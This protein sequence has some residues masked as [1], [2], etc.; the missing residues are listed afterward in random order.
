M[1]PNFSN[2]RPGFP[3][4]QQDQ[5]WMRPY[6]NRP[7]NEMNIM[8]S[9]QQIVHQIPSGMVPQGSYPMLQSQFGSQPMYPMQVYKVYT[10][11]MPIELAGD[12]QL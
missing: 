2:Q 1:N 6:M 5:R 3:G 9:Q 4:A 12:N 7:S 8:S 10:P 11:V